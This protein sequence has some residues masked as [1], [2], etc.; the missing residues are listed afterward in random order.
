[1]SER[2]GNV[3]SVVRH[4]LRLA[5]LGQVAWTGEYQAHGNPAEADCIMVQSFG[6]IKKADGNILP[7]EQNKLLADFIQHITAKDQTPRPIIAQFEVA[8]ALKERGITV[9]GRIKDHH[10]PGRYLDSREV[11]GQSIEIMG[12]LRCKLPMLVAAPNHIARVD[13]MAR[14]RGLRTV[15]PEGIVAAWDDQ[16]SQRWT[17]GRVEWVEREGLFLAAAGVLGLLNLNPPEQAASRV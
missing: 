13:A 5:K 4:P 10:Q 8:D 15:V 9:D 17:Q 12:D 2:V 7:G 16:S 1:M 3:L 6:Y 11:L 14:G